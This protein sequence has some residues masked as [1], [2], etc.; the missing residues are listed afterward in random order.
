MANWGAMD[1]E[2]IKKRRL[3]KKPEKTFNRG[4][5]P[6]KRELHRKKNKS[7]E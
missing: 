3:G 6:W 4:R 1:L 7:Q 5:T 2:G